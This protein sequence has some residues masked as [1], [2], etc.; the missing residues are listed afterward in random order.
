[1]FVEPNRVHPSR[2]RAMTITGVALALV[3]VFAAVSSALLP[4]DH[5][6]ARADVA[7]PPAS[8]GA[9]AVASSPVVVRSAEV[10]AHVVAASAQPGIS[11]QLEVNGFVPG[12]FGWA[13]VDVLVAGVPIASIGRQVSADGT[14]SATIMI[15]SAWDLAGG[16]LVRLSTIDEGRLVAVPLATV[17]VADSRFGT[18]PLDK[19]TVIPR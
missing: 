1:M 17:L 18:W 15:P 7:T 5:L 10:S 19:R 4:R 14:F 3:A 8:P 13:A 9:T 6:D 12:P 16:L 2:R 11:E